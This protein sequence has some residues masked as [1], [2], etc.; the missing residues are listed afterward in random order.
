MI[1][2]PSQIKSYQSC[3]RQWAFNKVHRLARVESPGLTQGS[4]L[5]ARVQRRL[6]GQGPSLLV[7]VLVDAQEKAIAPHLPTAGDGAVQLE[8]KTLL[9]PDLWL[10]G[11]MD[12]FVEPNIVGDTK[13][14]AGDKRT[15]VGEGWALNEETLPLDTQALAYTLLVTRLSG[16]DHAIC[17]WAYVTRRL[18]RPEAWTV[19]VRVEAADAERWAVDVVFPIADEM[20]ALLAAR[21][22]IEDILHDPEA[23]SYGSPRRC[24]YAHICPLLKGPIR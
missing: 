4:A 2:S 5:D 14:T 23:C 13:T 9:R 19:S 21:P 3:P 22:P 17:R 8:L 18:P 6:N 16:M 12:Y 20:A 7:D 11:K 1:L 24:S 15:A 10:M